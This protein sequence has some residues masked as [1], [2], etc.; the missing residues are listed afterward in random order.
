MTRRLT[1]VSQH[2][3]NSKFSFQQDL[4]YLFILVWP[5]KRERA[6]AWLTVQS[7]LWGLCYGVSLFLYVLSSIW[8]SGKIC[9]RIRCHVHV[10]EYCTHSL[11]QNFSGKHFATYKFAFPVHVIVGMVI[12]WDRPS[13][14]ANRFLEHYSLLLV[15]SS[16]KHKKS[17]EKAKR[18]R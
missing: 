5:V 17:N 10:S 8:I 16:G 3:P 12:S 2:V 15:W 4:V 9:Q 13:K 6:T 11:H 14:T 18:N 7:T 1:W